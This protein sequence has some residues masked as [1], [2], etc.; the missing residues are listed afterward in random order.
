MS[1]CFVPTHPHHVEP[2]DNSE[3]I[4]QL[5]TKTELSHTGSKYVGE[6]W[7]TTSLSDSR[8][9]VFSAITQYSVNVNFFSRRFL[10]ARGNDKAIGEQNAGGWRQ[11]P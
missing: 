11:T 8:S 2:L 4:I 6:M 5:G 10:K 1:A 9:C 7:F 3:T